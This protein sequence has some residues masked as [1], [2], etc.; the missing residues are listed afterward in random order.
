[1]AAIVQEFQD[2]IE[3]G[4]TGQFHR[5]QIHNGLVYSLNSIARL[6]QNCLLAFSA[7]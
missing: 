2:A 6:D 1:M 7:N 3:I 5:R 4:S